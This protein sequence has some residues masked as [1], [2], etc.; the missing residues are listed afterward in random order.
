[1]VLMIS[2]YEIRSGAVS[3]TS[4]QAYSLLDLDLCYG[5]S[6]KIEPLPVR[7]L[8][9]LSCDDPVDQLRRAA[10]PSASSLYV[11]GHMHPLSP[12]RKAS[13]LRFQRMAR[14]APEDD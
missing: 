11:L 9:V 13:R 2:S 4:G 6:V 12:D 1:M 10:T 7:R 5:A 8:I 3:S 14:V